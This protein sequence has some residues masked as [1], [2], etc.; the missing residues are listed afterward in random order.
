MGGVNRGWLRRGLLSGPRGLVLAVLS[1]VTGVPLLA[2]SV[3]SVA[4][5]GVG[6]GLF[7][8][9]VTLAGV[10]AVATL[11]RRLAGAWSG[12]EIAVPYRPRPAYGG[13][14]RRCRWLLGDPATWRDLLWLLMQAPIGLVLGAVPA[15][16]ILY[17]LE[18]VLLVPLLVWWVSDG[19]GYGFVWPID[20]LLDGLFSL[21]QGALFLLLAITVGPRLLRVDALLARWLLAPTQTA[22]LAQRVQDLTESRSET[23]DAQAAELRR[24]ERDLHD[25]TQARLVALSMSIGLAQELMGRDPAAARRLLTEAH[26]ASTQALVELRHLVRGIHPPA[27]VERG[28]DGAIQALALAVPLPV[29]LS[30]DLPGR[31]QAPVESAVYFAVAET[32]ANVTKH[33]AAHSAYITLSYGGGRLRAEIGDDGV[34]GADA[35]GGTG[36]RGIQR[37]LAALDG[38]MVVASPPGGPTVITMEL[39]CELRPVG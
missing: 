34:G 20:N 22:R 7:A 17:G 26:D 4:L 11:R 36:L 24:I 8:L 37:R 35:A 15:A 25:G 30:L 6:V 16:L 14:W 5:L 28:L 3:A 21:P 19:Y 38:T 13:P 31:T 12:V 27:L 39:P 29:A 9:P 2:L 18:G 1:P 23:V 10:R 33:S 32:L